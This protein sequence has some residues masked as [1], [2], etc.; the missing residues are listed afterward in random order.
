MAFHWLPHKAQ[1]TRKPIFYT[2]TSQRNS[3]CSD[4]T[5]AQSGIPL[6]DV[7]V[8]TYETGPCT[9][10]ILSRYLNNCNILVQSLKIVHFVGTLIQFFNDVC[11]GTTCEPGWRQFG[12]SCYRI[13]MTFTPYD[14]ARRLCTNAGAYLVQILSDEENKFV[15]GLKGEKSAYNRQAV[16]IGY[17][18][19]GNTWGWIYKG[20][21]GNYTKWHKGEPRFDG[22]AVIS[23]KNSIPDLWEAWSCSPDFT[24]FFVCEKG[25][26][27]NGLCLTWNFWRGC[28]MRAINVSGCCYYCWC[29]KV[30]L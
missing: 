22:C 18:T 4:S 5:T 9:L 16:W 11:A 29:C 27:S 1:S 12:G 14:T 10:H 3:L 21:N 17:H 15:V 25:D 2:C 7:P 13:N 20:T 28:K 19:T 26:E 30:L 8:Q 23:I 6:P 24:A